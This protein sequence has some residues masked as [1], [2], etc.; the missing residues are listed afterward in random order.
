MQSPPPDT[1]PGPAHSPRP[2]GREATQRQMVVTQQ[3]WGRAPPRQGDQGRL[4]GGGGTGEVTWP[5]GGTP[6]ADVSP[7]ALCPGAL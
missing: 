2:P 1:E 3:G 5:V 7:S 6:P 4:P